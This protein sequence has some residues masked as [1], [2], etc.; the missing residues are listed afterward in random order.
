VLCDTLEDPDTKVLFPKHITFCDG[1]KARVMGLGI[2][3]VSFLRIKVYV[4]GL[5]VAENDI[6]TLRKWK[7]SRSRYGSPNYADVTL[8][9]CIFIRVMTKKFFFQ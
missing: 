1:T 3:T 6:R 4:I 9:S 7:V 5:Y 2:R 8:T